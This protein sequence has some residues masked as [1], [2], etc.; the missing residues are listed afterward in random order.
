MGFTL[1]DL[2]QKQLTSSWII[3]DDNFSFAFIAK[4]QANLL[5]NLLKKLV[6]YESEFTAASRAKN[7]SLVAHTT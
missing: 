2:F 5:W 1:L 4:S 3:A 7:S 6:I